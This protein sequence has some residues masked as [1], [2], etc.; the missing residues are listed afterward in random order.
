[1]FLI[2][3]TNKYLSPSKLSFFFSQQREVAEFPYDELTRD[4]LNPK[5]FYDL[6]S[7]N[8]VNFYTGVP[9][10]LLKDFCAYITDN[11]DSKNHIIAS[12]EGS[13]IATAVGYHLAT[14]KVPM[15]YL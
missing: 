2:R 12:N 9:D 4:F 3:Q 1:M 5:D 11:S 13:A 14:N 15:V 8:G 6:L 7:R 10:S